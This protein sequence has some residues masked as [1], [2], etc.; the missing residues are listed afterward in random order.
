M[1]ATRVSYRTNCRR[2]SSSALRASKLK[3]R[4]DPDMQRMGYTRVSSFH[5]DQVRRVAAERWSYSVWRQRSKSSAQ[6]AGSPGLSEM[7]HDAQKS[8]KLCLGP[9]VLPFG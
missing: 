4:D 7:P 5:S 3:R 1:P 8:R 6:H 2:V 9:K